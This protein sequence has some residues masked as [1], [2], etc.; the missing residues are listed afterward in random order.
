MLQI[1]LSLAKREI[2]VSSFILNEYVIFVQNLLSME[3][4]PNKKPN[5][6]EIESQRE[7]LINK[8]LSAASNISKVHLYFEFFNKV[9]PYH[10]PNLTEVFLKEFI[11]DYIS[12]IANFDVWGTEPEKTKAILSQLTKLTEL[13][14]IADRFSVLKFEIV[15]IGK[16][17][18]GL[19]SILH[20]RDEDKDKD[21]E[22]DK[23]KDE[24]NDKEHKAFFPLIDKEAA[25]GFYGILESVTVVINKA[26]DDDKFIIVPSEKEIEKKILEQTKTSWYAA[27]DLSKAYI[28]KPYKYH[29]VII[30][31]DKRQGFYEGRSL[32]IALTVSFLEQLLKFYNP[33]Y[34][35]KI[36]EQTAFTG[37]MTETGKVLPTGEE[38]IKQKV[39]AVFF[40]EVNSFVVAKDDEIPAREQ[41]LELQKEYPQRNLKLIP[42]EDISDVLNRRDVVDIRKQKLIVRTGKFVK[43][44]WVSAVVTVLL[45][46]LFGY[47]FVVDWDDN[48]ASLTTDGYTAFIKNKNGKI[49]WTIK[50]EFDEKIIN[51]ESAINNRLKIVDINDDG[52][53]EV[54]YCPTLPEDANENFE[55]GSV[56]C[57]NYKKDLLWKYNF[58]DTVN[59]KRENLPPPYIIEL[60][61]T[62]NV[63]EQKQL[64]VFANS[65]FSYSCAVFKLNLQTGERID[66]F[67][68]SSGN[69][70]DA[71]FKDLD[72]DG[73]NELIQW[74]YDNGYED[75]VLCCLKCDDINGY[76]PTTDEY[77]ILGQAPAKL[78]SYIRI[79]KNDYEIMTNRRFSLLERGALYEAKEGKDIMFTINVYKDPFKEKEHTVGVF[80][81]VNKNFKDVDI[82]IHDGFRIVRDSLVAHGLLETPY[83]DTK[84]Y[85]DILKSKIRYYRDGKWVKREELE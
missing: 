67:F 71:F 19:N 85:I 65:K 46:I 53:N 29:E 83:T 48:P 12:S 59:S 36:K 72:N 24:D 37:G 11:D 3:N 78:I 14:F 76:R 61:D 63:V 42:V 52:Q 66:S 64:L 30:S 44:N 9:L 5:I 28:K 51:N 1:S 75:V 32:G 79:P 58:K 70:V 33:T 40:S 74:G 49:L 50:F 20:P 4:K 34:F 41:L 80:Y 35:I 69:T 6:L 7:E 54:L 55:Y 39:K 15:R 27:L 81:K 18:E 60:I 62:I 26:N 82:F 17:L 77:Q 43:K 45:A 57:F 2:R 31:F 8:V 68:W 13:S 47:L 23:D 22:E 73:K 84:E 10:S 25:E 38:I 56:V 16:Q 21:E